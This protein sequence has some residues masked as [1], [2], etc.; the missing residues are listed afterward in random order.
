MTLLATTLWPL[1]IASALL[2][3]TVGMLT[4]PPRTPAARWSARALV[5]AAALAGCLAASGVVPGRT[6]FWL[7]GGALGLATYLIGAALTAGLAHRIGT[8]SDGGRTG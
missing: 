6:G 5:G 8:R 3:C 2:G 7:E 4:G 1:A